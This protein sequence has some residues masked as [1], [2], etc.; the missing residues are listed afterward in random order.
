MVSM[1][2]VLKEIGTGYPSRAHGFT[3]GFLLG[4]LLLICFSFCC[5]FFF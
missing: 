2:G 1:A 3:P 5:V 4:S